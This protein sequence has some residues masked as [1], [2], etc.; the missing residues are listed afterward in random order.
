M[1]RVWDLACSSAIAVFGLTVA[2]VL[3][4]AA[5]EPSCRDL[6]VLEVFSGV[7]SVQ[8]AAAARGLAAASFDKIDSSDQDLLLFAGFKKVLELCLRL[9]PGGLLTLAPVCSSFTFA[10]TSN[11]KRRKTNY[12][13][14]T[15]YPSVHALAMMRAVCAQARHGARAAVRMASGSCH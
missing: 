2:D 14:D 3:T 12:S 8:R 15:S 13:G 10:N 1:P 7:G 5:W 4:D 6:H 11:T 9:R